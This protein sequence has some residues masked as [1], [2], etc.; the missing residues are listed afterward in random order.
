MPLY[1]YKCDECGDVKD[2][3][4]KISNRKIGPKCC[5]QNMYQIIVP[6]NIQPVLGGGSF[7]GY[8]CP[9]TSKFVTSRKERRNI[10]AE[11]NLI[12]KG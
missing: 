10:I 5:E 7:Q 9:V 4:N 12:E 11:H 8:V 6:V 2:A 3:V 1:T